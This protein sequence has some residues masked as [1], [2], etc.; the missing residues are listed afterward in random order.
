MHLK[1]AIEPRDF[2]INVVC[3]GVNFAI[4]LH[5][6]GALIGTALLPIVPVDVK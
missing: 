3:I 6:R 1:L 5:Y 4:H 2:K